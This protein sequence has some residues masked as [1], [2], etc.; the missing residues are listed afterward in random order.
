MQLILF[1]NVE[2][3]TL[4]DS[5]IMYC[6]QQAYKNFEMVELRIVGLLVK[7]IKIRNTYDCVGTKI[8]VLKIKVCLVHVVKLF[9]RLE[10]T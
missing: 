8:N 5:C 3:R 9:I 1:K 4:S 7:H 2:S 10:P 6:A